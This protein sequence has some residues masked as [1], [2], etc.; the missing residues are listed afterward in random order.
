L[1]A[2][3]ASPLDQLDAVTQRRQRVID[4]ARV[5]VGPI[6]EAR[7]QGGH[8]RSQRRGQELRILLGELTPVEGTVRL[9]L[10]L[11]TA[12]FDQL[13]AQLD[14]ERSAAENVAGGK[15]TVIVNG[16]ARHIVGYLQDFLFSAERARSLVRY[17]SG[18]ERNRL[19]LARMF[20][21]PANV[22]VLD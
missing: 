21:Q 16:Q 8:H 12:Y 17:L 18:G 20:T 5:R 7:R 10:N 9:G 4:A 19:L 15:D 2:G 1:V 22:L 11:Q 6:N 14:E 13:R 3:N